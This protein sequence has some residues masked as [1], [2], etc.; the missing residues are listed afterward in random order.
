MSRRICAGWR[1]CASS[2]H[3]RPGLVRH[4]PFSVSAALQQQ[5]Q[6]PI[7]PA[8]VIA[9]QHQ[10][11]QHYSRHGAAPKPIILRA[12]I[13]GTLFLSIALLVPDESL[14]WDE[15]CELGIKTVQDVTRPATYAEKKAE[16][17]KTG[18]GLLALFAGGGADS[19]AVHEPLAAT[20]ESQ[21][22]GQLH[23]WV[24]T[25]PDP[26]VSGGTLLLCQAVFADDDEPDFYVSTH[27]SM[28]NDAAE[29]LIP[30]FEDFARNGL[31]PKGPVRGAMMLLQASGDWKCIY[32]DGK[33]WLNLIFLEWQTAE[34]MGFI[35]E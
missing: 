20:A 35:D 25:A 31:K 34:S 19:V 7:P 29:A 18:A 30:A 16:F 2:L 21:M 26:E 9:K 6:P 32:W 24:M 4:R 10:S 12:H 11:H 33:R 28:N 15:R 8:R 27:G 17:M 23:N 13:Y 14:S 1:N 22:E 3:L 5:Q